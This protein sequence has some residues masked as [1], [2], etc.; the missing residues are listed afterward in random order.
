MSVLSALGQYRS[1]IAAAAVLGF[2]IAARHAAFV[3]LLVWLVLIIYGLA[4]TV[5]AIKTPELRAPLLAKASIWVFMS[6]AVVSWHLYVH[7]STRGKAQQIVDKIESL[8]VSNGTYP[9]EISDIGVSK[10]QMKELLGLSYYINKNGKVLFGYA[11]TFVAFEYEE[12]DFANHTW[13][14]IY[15]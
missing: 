10:D 14:H 5:K 2:L 13:V 3:I 8:H 4:A 12:Y 9:V 1:T 15:D 6:V 11:S 7:H